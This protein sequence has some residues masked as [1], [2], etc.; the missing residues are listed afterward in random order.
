MTDEARERTGSQGKGPQKLL[1]LV[2]SPDS[3]LKSGWGGAGEGDWI[4]SLGRCLPSPAF[5]VGE[6]KKGEAGGRENTPLKQ[7]A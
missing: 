6:G 3:I 2:G 4:S 1:G 5:Q 7:S